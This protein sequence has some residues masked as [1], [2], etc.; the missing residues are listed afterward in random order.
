VKLMV[1]L[2]DPCVEGSTFIPSGLPQHRGQC[3][4]GT[5]S[6]KAAAI[7]PSDAHTRRKIRTNG[8]NGGNED[9]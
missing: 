3:A 5:N 9:R 6:A 8:R 4:Q 1:E 7:S 2:G